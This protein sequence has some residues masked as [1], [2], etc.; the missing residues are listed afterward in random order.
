MAWKQSD[1]S[2]R[3]ESAGWQLQRRDKLEGNAAYRYLY[4][5]SAGRPKLSY[6]CEHAHV[7]DEF[8]DGLKQTIEAFFQ[9]FPNERPK[10]WSW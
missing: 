10:G 5:G 4:V 8:V 1:V 3:L 2:E 7:R 6:R 9:R